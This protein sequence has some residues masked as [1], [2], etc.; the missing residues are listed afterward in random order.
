MR[1]SAL[2][3]CRTYSFDFNPEFLARPSDFTTDD[4]NWAREHILSTTAYCDELEGKRYVLFSNN[5]YCVFGIVSLLDCALKMFGFDE[6]L[7]NKYSFDESKRK[8]KCFIG[9]VFHVSDKST[10]YIPVMNESD[11]NKLLERYVANEQIFFSNSQPCIQVD[12]SIKKEIVQFLAVRSISEYCITSIKND[13][14]MF[15]NLLSNI[16]LNKTV[17]FCSNVYNLKMIE[18]GKFDFFTANQN[19]IKRYNVKKTENEQKLKEIIEQ[20]KNKENKI[21]EDRKKKD[22]QKVVFVISVVIFLVVI[23]LVFFLIEK[24]GKR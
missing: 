15:M 10:G 14:D 4:I 24:G 12:Y 17:N 18:D 3:H 8:I 7:V 5:R 6:K 2:V 22:A 21:K 20:E 16:T 1:L 19:T 9:F 13:E 11:Y 23:T